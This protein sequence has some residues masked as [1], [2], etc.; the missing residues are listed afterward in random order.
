VEQVPDEWLEAIP[1]DV[2]AVERR[3]GYV[4]FFRGRLEAANIFELEATNARSRLV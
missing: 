4:D 2:S 1:G 3:A